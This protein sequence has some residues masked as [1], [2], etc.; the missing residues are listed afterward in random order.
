M[1]GHSPASSSVGAKT[2]EGGSETFCEELPLL[3][4][5]SL[6]KCRTNRRFVWLDDSAGLVMLMKA[7]L[8]GIEDG[9]VFKAAVG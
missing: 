1:N 8:S 9:A 3:L 5:P 6:T 7:K 4:F 2:R